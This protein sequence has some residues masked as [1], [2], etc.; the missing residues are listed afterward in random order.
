MAQEPTAGSRNTRS[1][2][3]HGHRIDAAY[4]PGGHQADRRRCAGIPPSGNEGDDPEAA[5][6]RLMSADADDDFTRWFSA[7]AA[8]VH[9]IDPSQPMPPIRSTLVLDSEA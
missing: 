8:Q 3:V 5:F 1:P 2:T 9:G 4:V 6:A 7:K